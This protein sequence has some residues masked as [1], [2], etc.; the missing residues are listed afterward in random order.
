[1]IIFVMQWFEGSIPE[2]IAESKRN[3]SLFVVYIEGENEDTEKMNA[4]WND[5]KVSPVFSKDKCVA[6]KLKSNSEQ[7]TQFSQLFP[8]VCIPSVFFIGKDGYPLEIVGG[9]PSTE[10]FLTKANA[11]YEKHQMMLPSAST[12]NVASREP[13]VPTAH[14]SQSPDQS[15]AASANAG[16]STSGD[17]F[18]QQEKEARVERARKL[19]EQR[20]K[21]KDEAEK[22]EALRKEAAR[23]Q[24]GQD[25]LKA[26]REREERK[27]KEI[28]N[29]IKEDRAKERAAREA[30]KQQ[31]ARD[32]AEREARKEAEK[33][34]RQQAQATGT[35]PEAPPGR[36]AARNFSNVRLQFR[37]PDGSSVS[38]VFPSD[39]LLEAAR[40]F[41]TSHAGPSFSNVRI[42]T[43]YPKRELND[44][45]LMKTMT[46]LGLAP[47]AT[48]IV[49]PQASGS[50]AL[51]SGSGSSASDLFLW[52]LTPIF[53][54]INLIKSFLFGAP[55]HHK[56]AY[57][58]NNA[59]N[60]RSRPRPS[61][62][63]QSS[64][65]TPDPSVRRR[66]TGDKPVA[67]RDGNVFRLRQGGDDDDDNNTWNGNSTQQ[68]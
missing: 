38:Q 45:D 68:M 62:P 10:D 11:A 41:I 34:E 54:L 44:D 2:A 1:M 8:V 40:Q 24:E 50:S 3:K 49:S 43:S 22:Q 36:P 65:T 42:F 32:R 53:V 14:A 67:N 46:D 39:A 57:G 7:C 47:S 15:S 63:T 27:A 21:E 5:P 56:G 29:Q 4:T 66:Q 26:K 37:L 12:S 33:Q 60:D 9:A 6:I 18:A 19:I 31:I 25:L 58:G 28:L 51:T 48:L 64:S 13:T 17:S 20:Q 61:P 52:I 59:Q 55:E 35:S 30:V 23:R 16:S